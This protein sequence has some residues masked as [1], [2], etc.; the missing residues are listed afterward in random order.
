MNVSEVILAMRES[1]NPPLEIERE[2]SQAKNE[3]T[4]LHARTFDN[5]PPAMNGR[6]AQSYCHQDSGNLP[7]NPLQ[8]TGTKGVTAR[9]D[10]LT[11]RGTADHV[12][13]VGQDLLKQNHHQGTIS[14]HYPHKKSILINQQPPRKS[15]RNQSDRHPGQVAPVAPAARAVAEAP[16]HIPHRNQNET[17]A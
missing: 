10:P 3:S 16:S 1:G 7:L 12:I 15:A 8:A 13:G 6:G 9:E 14:L 11:P 4:N 5:G 2:G 17:T